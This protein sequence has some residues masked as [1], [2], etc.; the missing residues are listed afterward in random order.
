LRGPGYLSDPVKCNRIHCPQENYVTGDGT[1]KA[2]APGFF[3]YFCPNIAL[4]RN[5]CTSALSFIGCPQ[6]E[7]VFQYV[8]NIYLIKANKDRF[9]FRHKLG[10]PYHA[11]PAPTRANLHTMLWMTRVVSKTFP[12]EITDVLKQRLSPS[13]CALTKLTSILYTYIY[14]FHIDVRAL[15]ILNSCTTMYRVTSSQLRHDRH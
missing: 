3:I 14:K 7:S 11:I 5:I 2:D 10:R 12:V 6:L 4:A 9:L 1:V 13:P 8:D 15:R